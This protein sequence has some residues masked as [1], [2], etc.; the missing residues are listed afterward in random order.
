MKIGIIATAIA[1]TTLAAAAQTTD[2]S[3]DINAPTD[4][5]VFG[6]GTSTVTGFV[7]DAFDAN[8]DVDVFTFEIGAGTELV[9]ITYTADNANAPFLGIDAGDTFNQNPNDAASGPDAQFLGGLVVR[10][11]LL[12]GEEVL[13]DADSLGNSGIGFGFGETLGPGDYTIFL[14][15]I[16]NN[17]TNYTLD[18]AVAPTPASASLLGLCGLALSRRRR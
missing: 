9:S 5:G 11:D 10:G 18:F 6:V 1:G 12:T 2:F 3:D 14:Q 4:L 17:P 7:T 13:A 8:G 16:G 15:Q